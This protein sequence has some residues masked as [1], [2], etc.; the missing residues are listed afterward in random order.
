M[1]EAL[2]SGHLGGAYLDVTTPE[3]LPPESPLWDLPNV[4][5]SPHNSAISAGNEARQLAIFCENLGRWAR[6]EKLV[7][8]VN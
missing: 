4:V 1:I 6:G 7:N 3:P 2:R 5:I 8:E